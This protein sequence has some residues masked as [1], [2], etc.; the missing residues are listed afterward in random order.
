M[1]RPPQR[2]VHPARLLVVALA[3]LG[4]LARL[5]PAL[6]MTPAQAARLPHAEPYLWMARSVAEG[7]GSVLRPDEGPDADPPTL[8]DRMPG[9]P[10]L[11]GSAKRLVDA[12]ARGP[13]VVQAVCGTGVMVLAAWMA[14]RLAGPWAAV[15]AAALLAFAPLAALLAA[16]L[17]PVTLTSLALAA[18]SAAGIGYLGAVRA[19][20]PIR[21]RTGRAWPW[22]VG[23]GLALAAAAYLEAWT[24]VLAPVALVAAAVSRGRRRLLGGWAVAV[25]VT[26]VALGP[27]LVRNA[28]RLGAPVLVTRTGRALYATTGPGQEA[29]VPPEGLDE[30]GRDVFYLREAAGRMAEAPG[31]WFLGAARRAG[32]LWSPGLPPG[33]EDGP[34]NPVAGYATLLPVA[35][36]ALVGLWLLRRRAE[37][38][39]LMLGPVAVTAAQALAGGWPGARTAV[40]AALAALAGAGLVRLLGRSGRDALAD[41]PPVAPEAARPQRQNN[42]NEQGL[43]NTQ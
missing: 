4:L 40:A 11:I 13:L 26:L 15:V 8:A 6:M 7:Q 21:V 17:T 36:L 41:K 28:V 5:T 3:A 30:V 29:A 20:R 31:R 37:A 38:W 25:A 42:N 16:L 1:A 35:G 19:G 14:H 33:L 24:L 18:W 39:W 27:W 9:Y 2:G 23:A 34:L 22:A 12:P 32:R 10:L 43:S